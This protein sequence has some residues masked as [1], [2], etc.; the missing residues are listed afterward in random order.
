MTKEFRWNLEEIRKEREEIEALIPSIEQEEIRTNLLAT[1]IILEDIEA[2]SNSTT[3]NEIIEVSEIDVMRAIRDNVTTISHKSYFPML[4]RISYTIASHEK[5]WPS[6]KLNYINI[7]NEE[8]FRIVGACFKLLD[9]EL[10]NMFIKTYIES[11]SYLINISPTSFDNPFN[12]HGNCFFDAYKGIAYINVTRQNTLE[13]I[14]C[15]GHE[16]MHG[17]GYV[18][19]QQIS[20]NQLPII[21][22]ASLFIE[23]LL[24]D[25]LELYGIATNEIDNIRYLRMRLIY[26]HSKYLQSMFDCYQNIVEAIK[27]PEKLDVEAIRDLAYMSVKLGQVLESPENTIDY[28]MSYSIALELYKQ[29]QIDNQKGITNLKRLMSYTDNNLSELLT[30]ID[31]DPETF[32]ELPNY[33]IFVK[34][35][36]ANVL[37]KK[38]T[39]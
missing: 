13:D 20:N 27:D 11:S 24:D 17:I 9:E 36:R 34:E 16:I 31:I 8:M 14:Y 2:L 26:K 21:E 38:R 6:N 4:S 30:S 12:D 7:S 29:Y 22:T 3:T 18:Y 35:V 39:N 15:L 10:F 28:I 23:L 1:I 32:S 25:C 33:K 5:E 37:T 19:N